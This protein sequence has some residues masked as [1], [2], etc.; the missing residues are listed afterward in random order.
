MSYLI[1]RWLSTKDTVGSAS[2]DRFELQ[3]FVVFQSSHNDTP[4]P[5]KRTQIVIKKIG[6]GIAIRISLGA[7]IR[8]E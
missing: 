7:V 2:A 6:T 8:I 1:S 5:K 3:S 4:S